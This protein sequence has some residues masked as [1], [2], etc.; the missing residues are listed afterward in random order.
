MYRKKKIFKEIRLV[1]KGKDVLK[2][3]RVP[4]RK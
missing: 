3:E 2:E 4:K 1:L